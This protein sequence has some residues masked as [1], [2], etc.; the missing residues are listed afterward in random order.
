MFAELHFSETMRFV[1]GWLRMW[2]TNPKLAAQLAGFLDAAHSVGV[3]PFQSR[4]S[5]VLSDSAPRLK[6]TKFRSYCIVYRF[7]PWIMCS[8][9][10]QQ[11]WRI[12]LSKMSLQNV[13]EQMSVP[14]GKQR[15]LP[16]AIDG[17]R[18]VWKARK[19]KHLLPYQCNLVNWSLR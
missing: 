5:P 11:K 12:H 17:F 3:S 15:A 16:V 2:G 19:I 6:N 8:L 1:Y 18:A 4:I 9:P 7:V 10:K 13:R 14:P